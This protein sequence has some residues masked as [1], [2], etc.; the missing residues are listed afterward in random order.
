MPLSLD[1]TGSITGIGTFNF[2]D[3]IVHVGDTNTKIRF[4]AADTVSVETAGSERLRITSTGAINLTS[5]NTTGWQLDAGDN[6]ASY[7]AIDNHFPTTNRTLYIN[8]ETTH[9]SVAFWNKNGSDGYGFGLDNSGNF[10][11]VYG[12]TERLRIGST[13]LVGINST[14][15]SHNLD[16]VSSSNPYLKLLRSGYNPVYIGNAAGEG[17]IETTGATFIKT[18]GSERLRITSAGK[19]G[20]GTDNPKQPVSINNGRVSI[21]VRGDYYG[22]W[23]DGDTQGTSSFN[24]GRWHNAG[25]RMRSGGSSDNDLIVETQNTS[26]NLQLQPSGGKV[27]IGTDNPTQIFNIYGTNLKP[28]IGDRTAH[29]PLYSS[30]NGQNNTSLEITSSGTG[31]NVAGLTLNNPTT[32]ANTSYKTISF[33]C[34]GTSSSEK[35]AAIISSNHDEDGSSSLKGNWYV[36]TNNGSGL[37]QNLQIN[38]DGHVTK[39]NQPSFL[40]GPANDSETANGYVT[41]TTVYHNPAADYNVADGKFTAP[42]TGYYTF[43]ANYVGAAACK[44]VFV[45][46]YINGGVNQ[47]GQHYSGGGSGWATGTSPYMSTD[48]SATFTLLQKNDYVQ[49]HLSATGATQGQSGYMRFYGYLVH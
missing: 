7:T 31:T 24:V 39:P 18:A 40:V 38:H 35:R 12:S 30:Y 20:I 42:V 25:G 3:E 9:R 33:S 21:D 43:G 6:S 19:I 32:A 5:E 14:S 45:R 29:T 28:V 36:S 22:A 34:S 48:L 10:K 13:G 17:V 46:F 2:S 44:N 11:V 8:N 41:Y 37:Q 15:P 16:I 4:P 23:I 1:G 49:L 26:H 27:G 47:R